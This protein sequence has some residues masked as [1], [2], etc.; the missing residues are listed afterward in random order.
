MSW[1]GVMVVSTSHLNPVE[2]F[3][4]L[5]KQQSLQQQQY[6][7]KLPKWFMSNIYKYF[8]LL[9]DVTEVEESK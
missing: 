9:H 2:A 5:V 4:E 7:A 3:G 8:V 6:P 1:K